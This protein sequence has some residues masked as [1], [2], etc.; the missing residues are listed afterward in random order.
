M[1]ASTMSSHSLSPSID[2]RSGFCAETK[3]FYSIRSP[4]PL[5]SPSLPLSFPS[6][7]FSLLPSPLPSHP[8]LINASTGET[9]SYPQFLSQVNS[10]TANLLTHFSIS[11]GDVVLVLSPTRMDLLVLYMSLLSIGAVVSPVNP[12]LTPSEISHLVHLS[13]PTFAFTTS[14]T[15]QKLPSGLNAILLDTPRFKNLLETTAPTNFENMKQ[16]EVLYQSDLAVIQYSSGTTG[17]IKAAALS[18]RYFIAMMAAV[19]HDPSKPAVHEVTLTTAPT[20]HIMGFFF[21]L[22]GLVLGGTTIVLTRERATLADMIRVVKRYKVTEMTVAPPIVVEMAKLGDLTCQDLQALKKVI[23]GGAP[24]HVESARRFQERFPHVLITQGYGST[25]GGGIS[26][27]IGR[28]ECNRLTS[29]G[30]LLEYV[31]VKIVDPNTGNALSVGQAGELCIK[32]PACMTGY[33][34]DEEANAAAFDSDGWLKTGDLCYIDQDGFVYVVDRLK[35]LIKYKAYQVPPAELEH[36][37][38]SHLEIAD[39]AV[40]PIPHDEVGQ[41]P[42]ALVVRRDGSTLCETEVIDYVAKQVAPYKKI[43]KV[44]FVNKIPNSPA[45]KI[46]RR[47]LS[48]HILQTSTSR[49]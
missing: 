38:L 12:A 1:A 43:R 28:E 2:P 36:V 5:P 17:R 33:I 46:L 35:E 21:S 44:I 20:F 4:V 6:L 26:R 47:E 10:L 27:M 37:L 49:L 24:L 9:T 11:K 48:N 25:E 41:I 16:I 45:G 29:A 32:S 34:G 14:S 18:H 40:V 3:T 31:Q 7:V 13:K 42:A 23:C 39:A 19:Y 30:R 22:K 15:S 8:A